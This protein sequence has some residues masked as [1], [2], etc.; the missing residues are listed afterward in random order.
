[1]IYKEVGRKRREMIRSGSASLGG[2]TEEEGGSQRLRDP[3]WGMDG[4]DHKLGTIALESDAGQ[5]SPIR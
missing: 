4:S 5:R 2:D 1:M 3:P